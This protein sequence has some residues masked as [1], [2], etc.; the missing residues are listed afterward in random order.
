MSTSVSE[1]I[2][3]ASRLTRTEQREVLARLWPV[4][5]VRRGREVWTSVQFSD[6]A[7]IVAY[8]PEQEP[9]LIALR[10]VLQA[11]ALARLENE[12]DH[13]YEVYGPDRTYYVTLNLT[14]EF[15]GLLSSWPPDQPPLEVIL[16]ADIDA[17]TQKNQR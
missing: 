5:A 14:K 4:A 13:T 2:T 7:R 17:D 1:V 6:T 15:A 16:D 10:D 8:A 12:A 9:Y 11:G 3:A